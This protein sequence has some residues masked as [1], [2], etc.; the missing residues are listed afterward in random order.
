V[1]RHSVSSTDYEQYSYGPNGNQLTARLRSGET[2]TSSYDALGRLTQKAFSGGTMPSVY[3]GYDLLGDLL[4]ARYGSATVYGTT[5]T[6]DALQRKISEISSGSGYSRTMSSQYDLAGNRTRLTY[7]DGNYIQYTYDPLNRMKQVQQNGSTVMAEYSYDS[8]GRKVGL[9]R[10]NGASTT[11][12]YNVA[13]D[14][15][16]GTNTSEWCLQQGGA[17]SP[18]VT[19]NM[20]YTPAGRSTSGPYPTRTVSTG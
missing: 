14:C 4:Y 10:N 2:A 17:M 1:G 12:V 11:M 7:P 18:A 20:S 8:L 5:F 16:T 13:A 19:Y 6:Y 15:S 9:A 3:Y